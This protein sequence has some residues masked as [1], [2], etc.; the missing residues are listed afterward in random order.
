MARLMDD[1]MTG[2][3]DNMT[4][5]KQ[6]GLAICIIVFILSLIGGAFLVRECSR[7]PEKEQIRRDIGVLGHAITLFKFEL[8]RNRQPDEAVTLEA[9]LKTGVISQALETKL[10]SEYVL[11]QPAE[12]HRENDVILVARDKF[13][14][15]HEI[16]YTAYP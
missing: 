3:V 4:R 10:R 13:G 7:K 5:R 1:V 12:H 9:L 16:Q 14:R 8:T 15:E 11:M 6:A 2:E